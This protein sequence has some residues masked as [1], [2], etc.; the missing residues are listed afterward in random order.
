MYFYSQRINLIRLSYLYLIYAK[1]TKPSFDLA[2]PNPRTAIL[3]EY[4]KNNGFWTISIYLVRHSEKEV[5]AS[6][7]G[8]DPP[9]TIRELEKCGEAFRKEVSASM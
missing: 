3:R 8:S 1:E 7:Y 6:M 5:S 9:L 2:S 4:W